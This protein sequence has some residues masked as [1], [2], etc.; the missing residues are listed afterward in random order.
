LLMAMRTGGVEL[1]FS[2]P[3]MQGPAC[4]EPGQTLRNRA[5]QY[6]RRDRIEPVWND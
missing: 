3:D 2:G 4:A 1:S 5:V 6:N